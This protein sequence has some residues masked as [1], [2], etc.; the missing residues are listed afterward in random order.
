MFEN[1][2]QINELMC[3]NTITCK[4]TTEHQNY[5]IDGI[6]IPTRIINLIHLL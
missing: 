3:E 2:K 4:Y 1:F 6:I 5:K